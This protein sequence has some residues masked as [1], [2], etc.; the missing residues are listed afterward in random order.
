MP[1][2]IRKRLIPSEIIPLDDDE[3]LYC[4]DSVIVTAWKT[5]HPKAEFSHGYSCY[6]LREGWKVSRFYKQDGSLCYIY[7][8]II[9]S[10]FDKST[11]T[12]TFTDLL[13]DVIIENDGFVRVVD[14]D[15]LAEA[16]QKKIL[17]NDDLT[18]ILLKLNALLS[19][20]YS[21]TFK[22]LLS[23][24]DSHSQDK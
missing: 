6:F 2:L 11:D 20:I 9:T 24:L 18:S 13:A 15:E 21:G 17:S 10:D 5:L 16:F 23:V 22:E 7:C 4:S 12:W 14:L 1:K 8:D 3:I 19:R